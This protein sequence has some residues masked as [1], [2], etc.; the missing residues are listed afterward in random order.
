MVPDDQSGWMYHR[1][2]IGNGDD[3]TVLEREIAMIEELLQ[4]EPDS[5]C[6]YMST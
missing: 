6:E 1:W 4:E 2:L 5:R 3:A